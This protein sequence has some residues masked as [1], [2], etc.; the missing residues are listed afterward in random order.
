M[1]GV[2]R[3]TVSF[4][5]NDLQG[6]RISTQ[7]RD[8]VLA[9]A[10]ELS[11][12][13]NAAGRQLA[14][15]R[16]NTLGLVLY[17][18]SEQIIADAFLSMLILG[19]EQAAL[20]QDFRVLIKPVSP[21]QADGYG[22]LVQGNFVDG[23]LLSGP[24]EDDAEIRSLGAQ[25]V[26][27]MLLGNLSD[28]GLHFVDVDN[29]TAAEVAVNHL[30][31]LGHKRL[32]MITNAPLTYASAQQ[33]RQGFLR[34][35]TVHGLRAAE[36]RIEEANLTP[37]SGFEAMERLLSRDPRP[38][39]V[40]VASDVV[41]GGAMLAAK[42][43]GLRVPEDLSI[44]GFDDIPMA[45]Y[46]DPPLTTIRLPAFA[47][48]WSGAERLVRLVLGEGLDEHGTLLHTELVVRESTSRPNA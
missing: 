46:M 12:R 3:T 32:A 9:A 22:A 8:R 25:G 23:I 45:A 48:G 24:R 40:F 7:T 47:L 13:P 34:A 35:L 5:L 11:Y 6:V 17:Q 33:R 39:A 36:A 15:G 1:A 43:S 44:V 27:I 14:S 31:D 21:G 16:S 4:V 18:S 10:K 38:T 20:Q 19:V 37:R 26:P 42:R 2:S 30:T 28:S 29:V 41:A